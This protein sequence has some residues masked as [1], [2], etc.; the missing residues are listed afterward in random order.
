VFGGWLSGYFI[1]RGMPAARARKTAMLLMALCMPIAAM[2]AF[3]GSVIGA[4]ALVS[5]ATSA[6]QGW[7]ANLF[8]TTSD[9]FP[10]RAVASV[11]GFGGAMG[12]F[13]GVI[14]TGLLPGYIIQNFG[15]PPMF[16]MMGGF[17][18]FG[19]LLLHLLMRDMKPVQFEMR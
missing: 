16:L 14:F 10:K 6:H 13:G 4:I 8:T 2:S 19:F 17:H 18:L 3:T 11:T 15:Y 5:L 12:A 7:S 9:V 1:R